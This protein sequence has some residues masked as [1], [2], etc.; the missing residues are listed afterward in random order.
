MIPSCMPSCMCVQA[1]QGAMYE[2]AV[3]AIR[4]CDQRAQSQ[5]ML[6]SLVRSASRVLPQQKRNALLSEHKRWSVASRRAA[7][8]LAE[9]AP[10]GSSLADDEGE[11]DVGEAVFGELPMEVVSVIFQHLD[12][13]SLAASSC[14]CTAWQQEALQGRLW[15]GWVRQQ[16]KLARTYSLGKA[17]RQQVAAVAR[18]AARHEGSASSQLAAAGDY[19]SRKCYTWHKAFSRL[20][21]AVPHLLLPLQ[22]GR[23]LLHQQLA[24]LPHTH[25]HGT[26][27]QQPNPSSSSSLSADHPSTAGQ[28][29]AHAMP[30]DERCGATCSKP[31]GTA[32]GTSGM[33]NAASQVAVP[34]SVDEVLYLLRHRKVPPSI[35]RSF[36][37]GS[38]HGSSAASGSSGDRSSDDSAS[39]SSSSSSGIDVCGAS[40]DPQAAVS[41]LQVQQATHQLALWSIPMHLR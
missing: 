17:E 39:S 20:V 1:T 15:H 34:V 36:R 37:R 2:D 10:G 41:R 13:L 31:Q 22:S 24:W 40:D 19:G 27:T 4:L 14:V 16:L 29:T 21:T 3:A 7:K 18:Q 32:G 5:A 11:G 12:P 9:D 35:H 26:S 38:R 30:A 8:K 25:A 6:A 23:V 28:L 33:H